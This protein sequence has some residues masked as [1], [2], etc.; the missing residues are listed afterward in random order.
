MDSPTLKSFNYEQFWLAEQFRHEY[1]LSEPS[2]STTASVKEEDL[3]QPQQQQPKKRNRKSVKTETSDD[4]KATKNLAKNYGKAIASFATTE[5]A[6]PYLV[7]ILLKEGLSMSD[8]LT[9]MKLAKDSIQGIDS[10]RAFLLITKGDSALNVAQK[11]AFQGI[12]IAFIKYFSVNWIM[13]GRISNKIVYLKYRFKVL[14]RIQNP[15]SFTYLQGPKP[16]KE[17]KTNKSV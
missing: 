2:L 12:S 1:N 13:H 9:Y 5:I 4:Y 16:R 8:F 15:E 11:R 17:T 3:I 10:F 14:R 6:L 7:P